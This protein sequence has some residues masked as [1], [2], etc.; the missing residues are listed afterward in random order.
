MGDFVNHALHNHP[1][2]VNFLQQI[3]D[4]SIDNIILP[5][6]NDSSQVKVEI[7]QE[8]EEDFDLHLPEFEFDANYLETEM[9]DEWTNHGIKK[10]VKARRIIL[11]KPKMID[12]YEKPKMSL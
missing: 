3:S 1:W 4:G 7:K 8:P 11:K 12:R 2:A 10:S 9:C 6:G 5:K